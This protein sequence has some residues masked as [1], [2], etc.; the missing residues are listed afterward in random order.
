M[1]WT[2]DLDPRLTD[3]AEELEATGCA[4]EVYDS[5]WRLVYLTSQFRFFTGDKSLD[6]LGVGRHAVAI[7]EAEL[8]GMV[9]DDVELKWLR[10]N[11]PLMAHSTPGGADAI[12]ALLPDELDRALGPLEPQPPKDLWWGEL[13]Y[14]QPGLPPA[15]T[16][17]V[18]FA[19]PER[20]GWSSS[21]MRANMPWLPRVISE[22][23][24]AGAAGR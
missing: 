7:R 18:H 24:L 20:A 22:T 14:H 10:T 19:L 13:T 15:Q 4:A 6:E 8:H 3:V 12:R 17:Y 16:R 1:S 9:P 2:A 5:E 23:M 11:I 21:T